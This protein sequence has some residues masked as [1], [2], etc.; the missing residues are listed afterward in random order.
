[1]NTS[2]AKMENSPCLDLNMNEIDSTYCYEL[3]IQ[4]NSGI[5]TA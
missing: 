1:M 5:D 4:Q 3:V 2:H